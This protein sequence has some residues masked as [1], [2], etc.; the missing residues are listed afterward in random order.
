M[1]TVTVESAERT[2]T[3]NLNRV[4]CQ[5]I[6]TAVQAAFAGRNVV[7]R[8]D[9]SGDS[10]YLVWMDGQR[11]IIASG[12]E[13]GMRSLLPEAQDEFQRQIDQV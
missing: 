12:S 10:A 7:I 9:G 13:R 8:V 4:H 3:G 6:G 11:H 5:R 2:V 1:T